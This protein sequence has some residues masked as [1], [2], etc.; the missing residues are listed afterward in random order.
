MQ[1]PASE[2]AHIYVKTETYHSITN[3]L[4][5]G[6]SPLLVLGDPGSGK[7]TLLRVLASDWTQP[8]RRSIFIAL[9]DIGRGE[10]FYY[11]LRRELSGSSR[12]SRRDE[13]GIVGGSGRAGLRA[14]IEAIEST[15]SE[16]LLLFDGVDEMPDPSAVLQ[17]LDLISGSSSAKIVVSSRN[18]FSGSRRLFRSIFNM[19]G[20]TVE[21]AVQFIRQKGGEALDSSAIDFIVKSSGGMPVAL[22]LALDLV[23]KY[24]VPRD[25]VLQPSD[26]IR[27]L[28]ER[29]LES[30]DPEHRKYYL[31]ALISLAILDRPVPDSEYPA[32]AL[33]ELRPSS[34]LMVSGNTGLTIAHPI[35]T[36]AIL[37][38]A[39]LTL[40]SASHYVS[41]LEFGAEEAERDPLLSGGFVALPEFTDVLTGKKN[42]IVG[43]RGTG[44]SAMFAHLSMPPICQP[45]AKK[46]VVKPI[47]HPADL[48]RR[49]VANGSQLNTADQFRAGWLTLVAYC[50]AAQI[51]TFSSPYHARAAIYLKEMLGDESTTEWLLLKFFKGVAERFLRSSVKIKLGPVEIEPAGK[52][53]ASGSAASSI[54]LMAFMK[55]TATS[56]V[57]SGQMALVPLDRVD[58]I[59]KYDRD[60]QQKAVQGLFLAEGDLAQ[61]PGI[62][63]II[64]LRSDLFKIYDIQEK[65]KLVSR[66]MSISWTK[67]QLLQFLVDRVLSNPCLHRLR[68]LI[69]SIPADAHDVALAAILPAEIEG[70]SASEWLWEWM[71]NGNGDV[72][73]RQI[74]LLLILAAQSPEAKQAKMNRLPIFPLAALQWGM[75]RLSE[76]SFKELVDDFRVAPTF[77]ANCRAGRVASFELAEVEPLFSKDEGPI[78]MQVERLERLGFL[79]RIVMKSSGGTKS[80]QFEVPKLFTRGW[81]LG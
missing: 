41:S 33:L 44:K 73:P 70:M 21:L 36:Q 77:L 9:R 27:Q 68:D 17:L 34:S 69:S 24:G 19:S 81:N 40:D 16:L 13:A 28:F 61:L 58:E 65:T 1:S 39:E 45:V 75:D 50:I 11:A 37:S 43:D 2:L 4:E 7:T 76:L 80:T 52:S 22:S 67:P 66:S 64:F 57:D 62:R 72:S 46:S 74:I 63:L 51:K 15:P 31:D 48:L 55:D 12:R 5:A 6:Q 47:P 79:E 78:S 35:I 3:A 56:L 29:E 26:V 30:V 8:G 14:T 25:G 53:G 59:H 10:D 49:L 42:I 71:E 32:R 38:I 23:R 20:L 60:M 54:D 18:T